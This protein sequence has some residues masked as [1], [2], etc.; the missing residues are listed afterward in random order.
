MCVGLLCPTWAGWLKRVLGMLT[1]LTLPINK[2]KSST[3][4]MTGSQDSSMVLHQSI[5]FK[6]PN[7]TA[8]RNVAVF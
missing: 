6:H 8:N 4:S 2:S 7:D 3:Q 1:L 5:I